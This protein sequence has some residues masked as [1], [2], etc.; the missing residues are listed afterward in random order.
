MKTGIIKYNAAARGR[1]FRGVD[2]RF[3]TAR[4][5]ALINGGDVQE[6]VR[7]RDLHGYLGHWVRERF[8]MSPK[9]AVIHDGRV[10]PLEPAL[11]TTYL[12]AEPNGDIEHEAEFLDTYTGRTAMRMWASR[13][14][15]FSSAIDVD[16]GRTDADIPVGFHG[17]D[18]VRE[19][20][21]TANRGFALDGCGGDGL[22]VSRA[23]LDSVLVDHAEE[24][25]ALDAVGQA[26]RAE[27]QA[28]Q[29]ALENL[30]AQHEWLLSRMASRP[31]AARIRTA[32]DSAQ[33]F[34]P[35]T[36][37]EASGPS[38]ASLADG[39]LDMAL[40]GYEQSAAGE[41]ERVTADMR[42]VGRFVGR[43]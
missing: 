39:F 20:N 34:T 6:R 36:W 4:L 15:G 25:R 24:L 14:G 11:V 35:S 12:R 41:P 17:F 7:N 21:Y 23:A 8:G 22:M 2:R 10:I 28:A 31:D 40:P 33:T 18:F 42:A 29:E 13:A 27:L 19:P 26:L 16:M 38:P 1:Q 32:L 30:G 43:R 3:D 37:R 5:A 9:E